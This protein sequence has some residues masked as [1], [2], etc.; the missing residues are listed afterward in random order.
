MKRKEKLAIHE[1]NVLKILH[2]GEEHINDIYERVKLKG[3]TWKQLQN[4]IKRLLRKKKIVKTS[5][6]YFDLK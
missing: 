2:S 1:E 5:Y 4:T 6:N 3:M